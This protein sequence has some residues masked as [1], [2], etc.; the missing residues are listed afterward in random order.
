VWAVPH[1][2]GALCSTARLVGEAPQ[3]VKMGGAAAGRTARERRSASKVA[4]D[5]KSWSRTRM[6]RELLMRR[7]CGGPPLLDHL[8]GAVDEYRRDGEAKRLGG[9]PLDMLVIGC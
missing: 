8:V 3:W 1:R 9:S 5:A 2:N 6:C 7:W 4:V